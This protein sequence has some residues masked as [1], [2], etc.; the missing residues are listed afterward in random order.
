MK[1]RRSGH[2]GVFKILMLYFKWAEK[3]KFDGPIWLH[4]FHAEPKI[5]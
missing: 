3:I 5:Y 1:A 2:S 4:F